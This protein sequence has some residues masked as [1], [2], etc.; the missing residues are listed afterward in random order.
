M[1]KKLEKYQIKL[2]ENMMLQY[3]QLN[4]LLVNNLKKS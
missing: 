2:S 3:K 1:V 4:K